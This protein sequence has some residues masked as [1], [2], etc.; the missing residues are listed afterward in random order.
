[1]KREDVKRE[2]GIGCLSGERLE[3]LVQRLRED[4]NVLAVFLFGSQVDGYATPESDVDLAV[5]FERGP[6]LQEELDLGVSVCEALGTEKVDLINLNRAH[7]LLRHR[8]ISG[9]VLYER[10]PIRV[11]D[12]IEET[13]LHYIDYEPDLRAFYQDYDQALEEAYGIRPAE[14]SGAD[15]VH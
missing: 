10:D 5:L 7:L 13:I 11:S 9:R 14:N 1:M 15:S 3:R 4:P 6:S 12:F 8:A 2:R